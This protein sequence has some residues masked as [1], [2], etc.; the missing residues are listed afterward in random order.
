MRSER[1]GVK[2]EEGKECK[3]RNKGGEGMEAWVWVN[4]KRGKEGWREG[5]NKGK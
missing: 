5:K 4:Y 3:E 1:L 2:G